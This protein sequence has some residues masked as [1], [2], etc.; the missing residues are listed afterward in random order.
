[1]RHNKK[2]E[3][4]AIGDELLIGLRANGHLTYVGEQ[5]ARRGLRLCAAAEVPDNPDAIRRAF[6][7]AWSRSD[8]IIVSGGLGPTS[9]DLTCE[10][11]ASALGR[12]VQHDP[13]VEA[14]IREFFRKRN[15]TP[16]ANNFKQCGVIQGAEALRNPNG[17]A[18]GQWF[19]DGNGRIA[20]LLPG[21]PRELQPMLLEQVLPR[22]EALGWV[23]SLVNEVEFRTMGV[24]ESLVAERLEPMLE[25]FRGRIQIAYCAHAGIV[26]VRLN[27]LDESIDPARLQSLAEACR[28]ELGEG[29]LGYGQPEPAELILNRLRKN[30]QTIATAES[31][32]GGLLSSRFTDISGA[33]KVF[34]GGLVCYRNEAKELLLDLPGCLLD[35][36]GAV[37]AECAA[38]MATAAAERM[39]TDYA[40]SVTGF[41]G[42]GS[43]R[44]PAGTVY[45][46][47]HSPC[48]IW[49]R[50]EVFPGSRA[51]VK[52]RA[53]LAALNFMR[54][55]LLRNEVPDLMESIK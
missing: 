20:I 18:P 44:E 16:S 14:D 37:S 31:C 41:A 8:L 19:A 35:Q 43:G 7:D 50:K 34:M 48:G 54:I 38:A 47:Y 15:R 46:G 22:L 40:L 13:S 24:G 39:E 33:S 9:D 26:D 52:E 51:E 4:L 25:P 42:P 23:E 1:M 6:A 2:V 28:S 53:V 12:P 29:F 55:Q 30:G 17:T 3:F 21:P 49:S 11:V 32:T 10:V 45:I 36:H 27:A 5:L